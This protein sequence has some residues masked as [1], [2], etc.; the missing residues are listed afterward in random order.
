MDIVLEFGNGV[1]AR[2]GNRQS[3]DTLER[4]PEPLCYRYLGPHP[5]RP[6][7]EQGWM[8]NTIISMPT[9]LPPIPDLTQRLW[10]L[11]EQVPAGRVTTPGGLAK[12]LGNANA[13]RWIGGVMLRHDHTADC[14]CHRVVRAGGV[15]GPHP[16]GGMV[17]AR[18]LRSEG[19]EVDK[20]TDKL[21][22]PH[23]R[24]LS[25]APC[26]HGR[27][28][29]G[30][31]TVD[32]ARI[33]FADFTSDRPLEKL[34]R[35]QDRLAMKIVRGPRRK[36]PRLVGGVDVSYANAEQGVAAYALVEVATGTLIWSTT[37]RRPVRFPYIGSFLTFRELP[38]LVDLIAEVRAADRLAP[39]VMVDGTGILHPRRAGIASHLGIVADVPTIGVTKKLLC[40]RVDIKD[41]QA[42]ES[43]PVFLEDDTIGA[44]IRPTS[45]SSRPIY[46][47]VGNGLGLASVEQIVRAVLTG[48]RLPLPLYWADRLSRKDAKTSRLTG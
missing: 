7:V 40:G 41:M 25:R 3:G 21:T 11:I 32:L 43:R 39:V 31:E 28:E 14:P 6:D 4:A 42:M 16:E 37:I 1:Q 35:Y 8:A 19:V 29:R 45:A 47:S 12:A 24:P 22:C 48:R 10:R 20:A 13:A 46:I 18:R 30:E 23:P 34:A 15:L 27:R 17:K 2:S 5:A 33:D 26:T 36:V 9:P 38:L 44:A